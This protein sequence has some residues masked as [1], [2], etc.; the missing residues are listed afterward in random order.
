MR[1]RGGREE[2]GGLRRVEEGCRELWGGYP[3]RMCA[4]G[5]QKKYGLTWLAINIINN[6]KC[7]NYSWTWNPN[8]DFDPYS[9]APEAPY[10]DSQK[11]KI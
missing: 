2:N 4:G 7:Y 1:A 6:F 8:V 10:S 5:M 3:S 9:G 11:K